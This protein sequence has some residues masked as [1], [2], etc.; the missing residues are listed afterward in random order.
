MKHY[1][2]YRPLYLAGIFLLGWAAYGCAKDSGITK[3]P[4]SV[5]DNAIGVGASN[6]ATDQTIQSI[7][8]PGASNVNY[9]GNGYYEFQWTGPHNIQSWYIAVVSNTSYNY[10]SVSITKE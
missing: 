7:L 2:K 6:N 3:V 9:L 4:K 5:L 1:L 10:P 8:P